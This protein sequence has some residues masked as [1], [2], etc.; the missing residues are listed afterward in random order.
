VYARPNKLQK[1]SLISYKTQIKFLDYP[2]LPKSGFDQPGLGARLLALAK[3][4]H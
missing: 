1:T 2:G 4:I 3:S